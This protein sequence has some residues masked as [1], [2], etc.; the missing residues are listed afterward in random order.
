[1][2]TIISVDGIKTALRDRNMAVKP[3]PNINNLHKLG[4]HVSLIS[5]ELSSPHNQES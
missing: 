3:R 4:R 2:D 1:M 5:F